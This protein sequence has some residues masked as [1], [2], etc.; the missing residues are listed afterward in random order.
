MSD[1][2]FQF[3]KQS[4]EHKIES[5]IAKADLQSKLNTTLAL[6]RDEAEINT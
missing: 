5:E 2:Q 4:Q 3:Q 1:K 6:K